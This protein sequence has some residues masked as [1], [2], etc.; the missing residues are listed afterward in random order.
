MFGIDGLAAGFSGCWGII[1]GKGG[2]KPDDGAVGFNLFF[3]PTGLI[4]LLSVN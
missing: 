3:S 1:P 4:Y 2:T